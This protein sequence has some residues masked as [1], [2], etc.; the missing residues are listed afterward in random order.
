MFVRNF[1]M[2][3]IDYIT[4][5]MAPVN[6]KKVITVIPFLIFSYAPLVEGNQRFEN[7]YQ[8]TDEI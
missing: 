5:W 7:F 4:F 2:I 8:A 1:G 3:R 6:S